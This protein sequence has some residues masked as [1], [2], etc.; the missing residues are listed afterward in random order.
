MI[1][2]IRKL[3]KKRGGDLFLNFRKYL[4]KPSVIY[5]IVIAMMAPVSQS[6]SQSVQSVQSRPVRDRVPYFS[7]QVSSKMIRDGDQ[8]GPLAFFYLC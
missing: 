4:Q 5:F 2:K 7:N 1:T 8:R 3:K 6:I